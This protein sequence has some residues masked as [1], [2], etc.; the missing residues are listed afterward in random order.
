MNKT[1]KKPVL[2]II[3]GFLGSG[4]TT[5]SKKLSLETGAVHIN[6]DE[7]CVKLFDKKDCE[8]HWEKC[9]DETVDILW[10]KAAEY[11]NNGTD[12]I[13][14]MG[15]WDRQSRNHAKSIAAECSSDFK[16]YYLYV[17]DNIAKERILSRSGKTAENNVN[18]FDKIKK[19]FSEPDTD[20]D[21]IVINNY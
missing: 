14:D 20:E 7:W 15:F 2:Y 3:H 5:F 17:P 18:N 12:V 6:P 11:L 21:V 1:M 9:F 16:H 13:F 4:K 8:Q 19:R 10:K